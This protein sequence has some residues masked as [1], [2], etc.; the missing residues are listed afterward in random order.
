MLDKNPR[1]ALGAYRRDLLDLR[2]SRSTLAE[3]KEAPEA[4]LK[5]RDYHGLRMAQAP[6]P[7]S[8][9]KSRTAIRLSVVS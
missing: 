6:N 8:F 5:V 2:A 3:G 9:E 7:Y 4:L 1:A